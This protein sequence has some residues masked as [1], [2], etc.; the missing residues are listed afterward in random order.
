[1]TYNFERQKRGWQ[2][3]PIDGVGYISTAEMLEWPSERLR[4]TIEQ[5]ERTR[6]GLDGWRNHGNGWR[7]HLGLDRTSG[8]RVIDFGCGC[9]VEALQYAKN[10]NDVVVCD[11]NESSVELAQRVLALYGYASEGVVAIGNYPYFSCQPFDVFHSP[12]VVHHLPYATQLLVR[13]L[14]LL[15][16]GGEARLMLYSDK[17]WLRTVGGPLP[18]VDQDISTHPGFGAFYSSHDSVG[19]Y[20]DWYNEEKVRHKFGAFF[21]VE[22]CE[23]ITSDGAF[24]AT[25]LRPKS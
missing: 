21:D 19:A 10:G 18:P 14:E 16:V 22:R 12:G 3:V 5:L 15:R 11:V 25:V 23:Y 17:L 24:I 9:G 13:A 2:A 6:Y 20:A 7:E 4:S 8:K 1:M